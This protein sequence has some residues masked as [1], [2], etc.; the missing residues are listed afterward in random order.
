VELDGHNMKIMLYFHNCRTQATPPSLWQKTFLA[1]ML[2]SAFAQELASAELGGR[3]CSVSAAT[4]AK[5]ASSET[6]SED[7]IT[8]RTT[9]QVTSAV[10]TPPASFSSHIPDHLS[11]RT[12]AVSPRR[13]AV[14][15]RREAVSPRSDAVSPRFKAVSPRRE[16]VSPSAETVSLP[17]KLVLGLAST[18][19]AVVAPFQA[20]NSTLIEIFPQS[21]SEISP[22]N[23]NQSKQYQVKSKKHQLS[24]EKQQE[25]P[26]PPPKHYQDAHVKPHHQQKRHHDEQQQQQHRDQQQQQH[27]RD[28]QQQHH[29][30]D[31]QPQQHRDQQQQQQQHRDQQQQQHH[32]DQQQHQQHRDQQ[33]Q[34]HRDQQQRSSSSLRSDLDLSMRIFDEDIVRKVSVLFIYL[35]KL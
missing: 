18:P 31:Q 9:V 6:A 19:L 3:Q 1:I 30:R 17:H 8:H 24:S 29:H 16:A 13:E 20:L 22:L 2:K 27:H 32:R 33:Q 7:S 11:P 26:P 4:V 10:I 34:P 25:N 21:V 5:E 14:S 23:T 15:P 35:K 28:Q 12:D